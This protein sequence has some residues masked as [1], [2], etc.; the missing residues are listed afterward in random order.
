MWKCGRADGVV[1]QSPDGV[2][3]AG[4]GERLSRV[5]V[6][7]NAMDRDATLSLLHRRVLIHT[8]NR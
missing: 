2:G 4:E 8:H 1:G 7:P 5:C 6:I 3:E